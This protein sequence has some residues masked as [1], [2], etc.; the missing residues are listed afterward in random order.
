MAWEI[1][2]ENLRNS[3]EAKRADS[4]PSLDRGLPSVTRSMKDTCIL[5]LLE[6]YGT[7]SN[8]VFCIY[9][10]HL[11]RRIKCGWTMIDLQARSSSAQYLHV[12]NTFQLNH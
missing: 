6:N 8:E 1:C 7:K 3:L 11:A 10:D 4:P 2:S 12:L 5:M 9:R